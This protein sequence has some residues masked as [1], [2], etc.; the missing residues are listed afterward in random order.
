[1]QFAFT[2]DQRLLQRAARDVLAGACTPQRV[3]EAWE[4]A[5]GRVDGLWATLAELG[6]LGV[7]APEEAGGLGLSELELVLILEESGRVALPEPFLE[8]AAVG[9]PLLREV[10]ESA[11]ALLAA[12]VSGD[13][14]LTVG[15]ASEPHVVAAAEADVLLLEA[16]DGWHA[17]RRE[18]VSVQPQRSV[19]RS[20]RLATVSW[21]PT[22]ATLLWGGEAATAATARARDRGALAAAAQLLGLAERMI[23]TTIEY[24]G[25]RTQFGK[26]IGSFQAVKHHLVDAHLALEFARP[27]VYRAAHTVAHDGPDRALHVS[28]A[29]A[30][31]S[32]AGQ[33]AARKALQVHGAIG[34]TTECDLHLWMKRAWALAATWGDTHWHRDRVACRLLDG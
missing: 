10:G 21:T 24:A 28:I 19:D 25:V 15:L 30:L 11:H 33:L 7:T 23:A 22:P 2:E 6:L 17:L 32:D 12:A 14:T 29:K 34:Y 3:R 18:D 31:A 13:Q 26:P 4:N 16:A 27:A 8:T 1:M 20:R 9:V 5:T